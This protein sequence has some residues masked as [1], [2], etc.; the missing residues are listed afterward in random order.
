MPLVS[1]YN[2]PAVEATRLLSFK[3]AQVTVTYRPAG[4]PV[5]YK[6]DGSRDYDADLCQVTVNN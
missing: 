4:Y 2:V 1:S 6:L 3:S 5:A